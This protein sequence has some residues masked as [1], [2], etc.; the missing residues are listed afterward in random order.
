MTSRHRRDLWVVGIII[1]ILVLVVL[2][3]QLIPWAIGFKENVYR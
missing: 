2:S 3:W 1:L